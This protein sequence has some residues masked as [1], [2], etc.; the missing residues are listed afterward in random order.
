M[1]AASTGAHRDTNTGRLG[2][3]VLYKIF[4][5]IK[6]KSSGGRS[7]LIQ[8]KRAAAGEAVY[9]YSAKKAAAGTFGD[10]RKPEEIKGKAQK[11]AAAGGWGEIRSAEASF[12]GRGFCF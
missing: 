7:I 8:Q 11:R 5:K 2:N 4:F 3:K 12:S 1:P 6:W 9:P 10:T